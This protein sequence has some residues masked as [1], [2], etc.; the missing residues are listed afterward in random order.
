MP[1]F[2]LLTFNCLGAPGVGTRRR[3]LTLARE[4]EGA[5]YDAV[6]LQEVQAQ[7][8]RKLLVE[9]CGSYA[10]VYAPYF[11]APRGG[12][13]T[14]ARQPITGNQFTGYR[15]RGRLHSPA[16]VDWPLHK[17]VL[18]TSLALGDL[19]VVV[20]N[21]HLNANYRGNWSLDNHFTRTERAQLGQLAQIVN[22]QPTS[23]LIVVAG[24]LNVPRG[25]W[26]YDEFLALSGLDDPLV[27]DPRPTYRP[28]LVVPKRYA[29]AL[30]FVLICAPL[31]PDFQVRADLRFRERLPLI[32]GRSD[33][34][35]DHYAVELQ[36]SW[37][38]WGSE[39][40]TVDQIAQTP[41]D[42]DEHLQHQRRVGDDEN[43]D[44]AIA[45]DLVDT[46]T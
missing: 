27:D 40:G 20:L 5:P 41:Q 9:A 12:L 22:A 42:Q 21:T 29:L 18:C 23:T 32:G 16:I 39:G 14:L 43:D 4:L 35:S 26:L 7:I 3:L 25:C 38:A 1:T 2:T 10:S 33:Y 11:Y 45:P 19:A 30:D 31:L 8:Y 15:E 44:D 37:A 28:P 36:L 24:D 17:G 13:L 46:S 6:C 34:L